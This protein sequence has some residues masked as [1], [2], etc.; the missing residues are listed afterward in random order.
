MQDFVPVGADLVLVEVSVNDW[1]VVDARTFAWMDNSLRQGYDPSSG[2]TH[3]SV[4]ARPFRLLR[5]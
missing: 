2:K 1:E 5:V 3:K 4:V